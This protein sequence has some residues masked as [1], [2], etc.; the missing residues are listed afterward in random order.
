M[1]YLN[2]KIRDRHKQDVPHCRSIPHAAVVQLQSADTDV[3]SEIRRGMPEATIKKG[4]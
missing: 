1:S 2:E 4:Q 3:P